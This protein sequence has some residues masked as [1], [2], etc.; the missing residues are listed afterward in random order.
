ML[1]LVVYSRRGCHLCDDL[2]LELEPLC[3]G[4][5]NIVVRDVDTSDQWAAA[6][7]AAVPVLMANGREI[8]RYHLDRE[9]IAGLLD[10]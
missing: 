4:K 6:Y 7:G 3:A 2:L 1:E 8:C 9:A 10:T 5:A